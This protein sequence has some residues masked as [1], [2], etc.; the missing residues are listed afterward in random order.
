MRR[1][2]TD[3][4]LSSIPAGALIE[5]CQDERNAD[6]ANDQYFAASL[7]ASAASVASVEADLAALE[8]GGTVAA[9]TATADGLTTGL[10][11]ATASIVEITSDSADKQV[12]LPAAVD[13]KV[14]RLHSPT[15]GCELI[16][17]VAGDKVNNVVVGA[18]NE[19]ALAAD[20]VYT[21]R[22][23]ASAENWVMTGLTALGAV[24]GPVVPDAL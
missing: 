1:V 2:R 6:N 3:D 5:A 9:V 14:L 20:V 10:I 4:Q 7:L 8:A 13:G 22:Y 24:S 19:A 16:S 18:T 12:S 11:P 23:V 15:T 17:A 21:L